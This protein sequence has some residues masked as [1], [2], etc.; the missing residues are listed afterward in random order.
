M[1]LPGV[2]FGLTLL[3]EGEVACCVPSRDLVA[4]TNADRG[5]VTVV[6]LP[7][8]A[9][10]HDVAWTDGRL[11]VT[12]PGISA[13]AEIPDRRELRAGGAAAG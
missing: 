12:C 6:T 5:T 8:R 2:G 13:L 4:F 1:P 11:F 9:A 7:A 10:P 3:P